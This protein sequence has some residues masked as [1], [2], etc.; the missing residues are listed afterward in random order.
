MPDVVSLIRVKRDNQR[1][2][3]DAEIGWLFRAY[4][5]GEAFGAFLKDEQT[6]VASVLR[7]LGLVR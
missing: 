6:R 3:T 2:L 4:L 7:C 5:A 1:A